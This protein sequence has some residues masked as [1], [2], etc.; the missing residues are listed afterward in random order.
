[1][2]VIGIKKKYQGERSQVCGRYCI[3][4]ITMICMMGYTPKEF[5]EF[6]TEQKDN[7]GCSYDE[8]IASLVDI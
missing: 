4:C 5:E 1:M 8:L 2:F 7:Y 6:V 3:L